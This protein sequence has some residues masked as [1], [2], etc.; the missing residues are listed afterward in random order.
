MSRPLWD[1]QVQA[2]R[3]ASQ[4]DGFGFLFEQG[5]GK[6]RACIETLRL[7]YMSEKR[8][9]KTLIIAPGVVCPNW[10]NEFSMYSKIPK[11]LVTVLLGT[12]KKRV[13]NFVDT[14]GT[15]LDRAAIVV[16]NYESLQ[17]KDLYALLL[18]WR[19][20][21][22]VC[23]ESQ[24]IKNPQGKRAKAVLPLADVAKYRFILTGTPI[25][26]SPMD[27]FMQWRVLDQGRTFGKNFF[28]FRATYFEDANARWAGK[29]NY[30]P[31]WQPR[32][33]T[34]AR[35]QVLIEQ[36]SLRV[37][38]KDC[39][40]LPPMVRTEIEVPLSSE[41]TK[42]Y[43]QMYNDYIAFCEKETA[44]GRPRTVTAQ[45]AITKALRLQQ[46]VCGFVP[47]EQTEDTY[48]IE[49]NP[50]IKALE[51]LLEDICVEGKH[52]VIVWATFRQNY[53]QIEELCKKLKL[54]CAG[55][56]G[57]LTKNE[58]QDNIEAFTKGDAQVMIAN[59]KAG[60]VGIN[61]VEAS[62]SIYYSKSFS[63]EDD[64][65]SEARNYRGGSQM[66]ERVTRIDLVSR[67]TIDELINTALA[68]K[69]DISTNILD[70]R[71]KI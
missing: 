61:L 14:V 17:M 26:N 37:L 43:R 62:Y 47:V 1:H 67:G 21:V 50:R 13:D 30:F 20:E 55:I 25:L 11:E 42:M 68:N 48:V 27:V 2:I 39:L 59:Q 65:Q 64:L 56:Y 54:K 7:K 44:E 35:F 10:R 60:G 5:A 36:T 66:H 29:H 38:K 31:K 63:L 52:K 57:G 22:L 18:K 58:V 16:T 4:S 28:A 45:L 6:T 3:R 24:R 19:P 53:K 51:E 46:I 8:L 40:D 32:P 34:Y 12:G 9:M 49:D 69:Q 15:E 41:Q 71:S 23:D 33:D 70:W